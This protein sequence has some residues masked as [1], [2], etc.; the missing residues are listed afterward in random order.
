VNNSRGRRPTIVYQRSGGDPSLGRDE[1][2][3]RNGGQ[4]GDGS[5]KVEEGGWLIGGGAKYLRFGPRAG[6]D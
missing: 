6:R 3:S 1:W 5:G 4:I 2:E